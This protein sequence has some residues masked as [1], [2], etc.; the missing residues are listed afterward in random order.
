MLLIFCLA[1]LENQL[2]VPLLKQSSKYGDADIARLVSSSHCSTGLKHLFWLH[3]EEWRSSFVTQ[4]SINTNMA[5]SKPS[6][7]DARSLAVVE[8]NMIL[9]AWNDSNPNQPSLTAVLSNTPQGKSI[10][11]H[12]NHYKSLNTGVRDLLVEAIGNYYG[13]KGLKALSANGCW[14]LANQIVRTFEGEEQ[15]CKF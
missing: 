1:L 7:T 13:S 12:Y 8:S 5:Q 11:A 3:L 15:V 10:M 2:Y 14:S 6:I 9:D 4:P